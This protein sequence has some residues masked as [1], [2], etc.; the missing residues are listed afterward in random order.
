MIV[1][2]KLIFPLKK[3]FKIDDLFLEENSTVR[4]CLIKLLQEY[5]ELTLPDLAIYE[6]NSIV[7][8]N[9]LAAKFDTVLRDKDQLTIFPLLAG[10]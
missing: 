9:S 3:A 10:G 2:V 8:I 4:D 7:D 6:G 5:P 1:R